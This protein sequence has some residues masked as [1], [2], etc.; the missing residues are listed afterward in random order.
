MRHPS[1]KVVHG[2]ERRPRSRGPGSILGA[3]PVL[4]LLGL[5][6]CGGGGGGGPVAEVAI[7]GLEAVTY[8][9]GDITFSVAVTGGQPDSL[10]LRRDGELFQVIS[11]SSFTWDSTGAPEASYVFVARARRGDQVVDSTPRT[12]VVDRTA[13]EVSLEATPSATPM[14]LPGGSITL[15]ATASD[16]NGVPRVDFLDGDT[17]IG[18]ATSEP[19]ELVVDAAR[20][21]HAY[22]ARVVDL[23]G[24]VA[25]SA[26]DEVR[27]YERQTITLASEADLDGC[28]ENHYEQPSFVRRF[29]A[30]S[31]TYTTSWVILHFFSFDR[32]VVPGALVEEAT[33]RFYVNENA[34]TYPGAYLASVSY[35]RTDDAPP[36]AFTYPFETTVAEQTV[37][38]AGVDFTASVRSVDV[39]ALAQADVAEG[40]ERSQF[41]LR[42]VSN[43]PSA[44]GGTLYFTEAG[45]AT[46]PTLEMIVL[47]P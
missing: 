8:V 32:S 11:G 33:L 19:Y 38:V 20:G 12:V 42:S 27:V 40:R 36:T 43:G 7:V 44:I 29:T 2:S 13:A 41:R 46:V 9:N 17:V 25:A 10:E 47:A 31:C 24:N 16:G 37:P 15:V 21:I 45:E 28:I 4:L 34:G 6:A 18:S 14:V 3:A 39:T 22:R 23:A 1:V 30:G 5:A 26:A 35:T